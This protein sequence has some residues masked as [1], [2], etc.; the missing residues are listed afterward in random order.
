M[1]LSLLL[2]QAEQAKTCDGTVL[3][4]CSTDSGLRVRTAYVKSS[5]KLATLQQ[6]QREQQQQQ[7]HQQWNVQQQSQP[8]FPGG[9]SMGGGGSSN[10]WSAQD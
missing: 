10:D 4:G 3:I 8:Q 7:Q 1:T 6:Q 9:G 5:Q 2:N